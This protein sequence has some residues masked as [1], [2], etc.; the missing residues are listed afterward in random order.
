MASSRAAKSLPL[1]V[2]A[3]CYRD[4]TG[5]NEVQQQ[6]IDT[7][8]PH[9]TQPGGDDMDRAVIP[10][11]PDNQQRD[12][13]SRDRPCAGGPCNTRGPRDPAMRLALAESRPGHHLQR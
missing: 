8:Q 12:K 9:R 6:Q 10:C 7:E 2:A 3:I 13:I 11:P 1:Q 5:E 4:H